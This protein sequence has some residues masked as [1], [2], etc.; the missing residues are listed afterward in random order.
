MVYMRRKYSCNNRVTNY[1]LFS[2]KTPIVIMGFLFFFLGTKIWQL[3]KGVGITWKSIPVWE[4][5]TCMSLP[6]WFWWPRRDKRMAQ[7][8][9]STIGTRGQTMTEMHGYCCGTRIEEV[10]PWMAGG[11]KHV[12]VTGCNQRLTGQ[13]QVAEKRLLLKTRPLPTDSKEW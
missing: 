13:P 5:I 7:G 1:L 4:I 9:S 6:Y 2:A 12:S 11:V 8:H 3:L 10:K